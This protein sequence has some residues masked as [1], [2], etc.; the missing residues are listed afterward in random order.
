MKL[1]MGGP[2]SGNS[3]DELFLAD[4]ALQEITMA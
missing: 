1:L 4:G 2:S 3:P